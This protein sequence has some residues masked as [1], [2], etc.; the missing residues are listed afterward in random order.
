MSKAGA[1]RQQRKARHER[2]SLAERA[3]GIGVGCWLG[4]LAGLAFGIGL[5]C[6]GL[7]MW[8][9]LVLPVTGIAIGGAI[10]WRFP[11]P[12]D[13]SGAPKVDGPTV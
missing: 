10:G 5:A 8:L 13:E 6:F 2:F 12:L 7:T 1:K 11:F 9:W 3:I 4:G